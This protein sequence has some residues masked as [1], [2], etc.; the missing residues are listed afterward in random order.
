MW[1]AAFG[2]EDRQGRASSSSEDPL[3]LHVDQRRL[4]GAHD[5]IHVVFGVD[6]R[7]EGDV[8]IPRVHT[9]VASLAAAARPLRTLPGPL[10]S[11]I[12]GLLG[13]TTQLLYPACLW[14]PK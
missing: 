4:V 1:C 7:Q 9:M 3:L 14:S 13:P 5:T 10:E 6:G 8:K 12:K 11:S 2:P